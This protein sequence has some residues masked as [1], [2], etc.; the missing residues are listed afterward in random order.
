MFADFGTC[1]NSTPLSARRL[2]ISRSLSVGNAEKALLYILNVYISSEF[3]PLEAKQ[4]FSREQSWNNY[5]LQLMASKICSEFEDNFWSMGQSHASLLFISTNYSSICGV[6][7]H[8]INLL[9]NGPLNSCRIWLLI[10][11]VLGDTHFNN[12]Q[13]LIT[14]Y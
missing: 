8:I 4:F 6:S 2:F 9:T 5:S 12:S 7:P 14:P 11:A 10:L 13:L 3:F 1:W